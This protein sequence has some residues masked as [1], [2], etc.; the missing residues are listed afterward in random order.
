MKVFVV[1]EDAMGGNVFASVHR[2]LPADRPRAHVLE[3]PV[4]GAQA[5]CKFVYVAQTYDRTMDVH[6]F[7]GVY[8]DDEMARR[9]AGPQGMQPCFEI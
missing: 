6:R 1:I 3:V 8:C 5:D 7:E 2:T 9:A 4:V